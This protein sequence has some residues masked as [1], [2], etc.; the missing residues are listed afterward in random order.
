MQNLYTGIYKT[1]LKEINETT[2]C[3]HVL[4]DLI[5]RQQFVPPIYKFNA[6]SIKFQNIFYKNTQEYSKVM[7]FQILC[8]D[9]EY[10][11]Q[12]ILTKNKVRVLKLP[13]F[14]TYHKVTVIKP[15]FYCHK[16]KYITN[17]IE[18]DPEIISYIYGQLIFNKGAK[19]IK[20]GKNSLSNKSCGDSLIST[21]KSMNQD[22]YSTLY[23]KIN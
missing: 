13:N 21:N 8:E 16:D 17:G 6:I 2:S 11:D 12:A 20:W 1:L 5:L 22:P 19:N 4:K 10:S 9:T 14:K 15:L 3:I 7:Y 23:I 18:L